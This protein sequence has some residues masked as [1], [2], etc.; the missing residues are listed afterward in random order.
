MTQMLYP[1]L[2]VQLEPGDAGYDC[3]YRYMIEQAD[4]DRH[5]FKGRDGDHGG[6]RFLKLHGMK[7]VSNADMESLRAA[8]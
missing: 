3:G 1:V 6:D 7:P 5:F 4:H 8:G 2:Y